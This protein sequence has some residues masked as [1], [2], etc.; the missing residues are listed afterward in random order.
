M[1]QLVRSLRSRD[2]SEKPFKN[3]YQ[4]T[5]VLRECSKS[6]ESTCRGRHDEQQSEGKDGGHTGR[7]KSLV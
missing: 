6:A 7:E 3:D 5:R 4:R 1:K 2:R